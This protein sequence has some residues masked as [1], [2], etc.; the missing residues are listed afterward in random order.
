MSTVE[1]DVLVLAGA[2]MGRLIW[3]ETLQQAQCWNGTVWQ[4]LLMGP[5]INGGSY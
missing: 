1:R 4:E 5:D 2:D 3:N